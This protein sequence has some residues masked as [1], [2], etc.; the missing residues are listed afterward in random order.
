MQTKTSTVV[1]FHIGRGGRFNNAGHKTYI[2]RYNIDQTVSRIG[3]KQ[4]TFWNYENE[5]EVLNKLLND[6]RCDLSESDILDLFTN[7]DIE[8][9]SKYGIDESDLGKYYLCDHNQKPLISEDEYNTGVGVLDFDGE[10]DT[11]ICKHIE[12]CSVSDLQLIYNEGESDLIDEAFNYKFPDAQIQ[13]IEDEDEN[14]IIYINGI[15]YD[16]DDRIQAKMEH[17]EFYF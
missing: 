9:L 11:I 13:E 14:V 8:T 2:G 5:Q 1:C 4:W 3:D 10:Y 7:R 17:L 6:E 15:D 12:D 16:T